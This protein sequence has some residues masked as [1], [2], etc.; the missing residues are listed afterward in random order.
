MALD[1][2]ARL[3]LINRMPTYL[4]ERA[5]LVLHEDLTRFSPELWISWS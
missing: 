5:D 3:I 4:D 1:H 2:N